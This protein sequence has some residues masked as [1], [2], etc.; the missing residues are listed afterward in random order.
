MP[1]A[2]KTKTATATVGGESVGPGG[3]V[4]ARAHN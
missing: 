4:L 1:M 2:N 3:A